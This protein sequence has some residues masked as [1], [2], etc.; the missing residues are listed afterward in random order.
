MYGLGDWD[1]KDNGKTCSMEV[2]SQFMPCLFMSQCHSI[3]NSAVSIL[4]LIV[5]TYHVCY[6]QFI[7]S[8]FGFLSVFDDCRMGWKSWGLMY[9]CMHVSIYVCM[10]AVCMLL[11]PA[12]KLRVQTPG[13]MRKMCSN[14]NH[15][16]TVHCL[17]LSTNME[18]AEVR[19]WRR[20][21]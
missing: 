9:I 14:H 19:S 17:V 12:H 21:C 3:T 20:Q 1:W 6:C 8:K 2:N 16:A 10:Y 4:L 5:L 15:Y 18:D 13:T 7:H 11:D